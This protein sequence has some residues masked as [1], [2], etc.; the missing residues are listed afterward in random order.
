V[1]GALS[2]LSAD[3]TTVYASL[4]RPS[5]PPEKLPHTIRPEH[6]LIERLKFKL[7]CRWF[8]GIGIDD[9]VWD[10]SVFS[11]YRDRLLEGYIAAK[12]MA[13]VLT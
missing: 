11:K 8:V 4:R 9:A 7:L 13:A 6:Q 5:I 10:H 1:N 2:D 12:F 3:S